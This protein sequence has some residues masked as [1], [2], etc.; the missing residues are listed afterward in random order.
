MDNLLSVLSN[1]SH[2]S[3]DSS[4]TQLLSL[5]SS[6]LRMIVVIVVANQA[7]MRDKNPIEFSFD[8]DSSDSSLIGDKNN[9]F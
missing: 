1:H 2:D 9:G 5:L 4:A 7:Q 3:S 8:H 6:S